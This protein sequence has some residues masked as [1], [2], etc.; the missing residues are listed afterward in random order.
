M[1]QI[2]PGEITFLNTEKV[3]ELMSLPLSEDDKNGL[4]AY[5]DACT[6]IMVIKIGMERLPEGQYREIAHD[7]YYGRLSYNEIMEKYG[8]SHDTVR[9]AVNRTNDYLAEYVKWYKDLTEQMK[10]AISIKSAPFCR[11]KDTT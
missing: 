3:K 5:F 2:K 9:R 7:R 10:K 8:V 1:A 6:K 4:F 11:K